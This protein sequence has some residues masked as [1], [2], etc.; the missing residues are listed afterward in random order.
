MRHKL[1]LYFLALFL[2]MVP[3]VVSATLIGDTVTIAVE[4]GNPD[5]PDVVVTSG[6]GVEQW[7]GPTNSSPDE[8]LGFDFEDYYV[9]VKMTDGNG[10]WLWNNSFDYPFDVTISSIDISDF[11]SGILG[12][13]I[14]GPDTGMLDSY[15]IL[16]PTSIL[17]TMV[18]Q[19]NF[20]N[21]EFRVTFHPNAVP[22]PTTMLLLG[23][24]LIGLIGIGRKKLFKK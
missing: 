13:S 15:S 23:T 4:Y 5:T 9:D 14:S 3:Q 16:S 1:L 20:Y 24:G 7:F 18:N 10:G 21:A 19:A 17:L 12:L 2:L 8:A 11:A 22:E 6:A